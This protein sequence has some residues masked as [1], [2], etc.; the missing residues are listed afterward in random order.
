MIRSVPEIH[1]DNAKRG[2]P[3]FSIEFFPPKTEEG[4]SVL[5]SKTLPTLAAANQ[6]YCSVTYGAGGSTRDKTLG[7]VKRIQDDF[8]LTTVMHLTCVNAT[9]DEL[10]EVIQEARKRGVKNILALRGDPPGGTGDWVKT[11]GGFQ[12]S[13]EL[14][15]FLKTFPDMSI[16]TAGFPEGHIAQIAGREA[17]WEH[18]AHKIRQGAQFVVTQ[19]F[20]DTGRHHTP[21]WIHPPP[22]PPSSDG[23][24]IPWKHKARIENLHPT[25]ILEGSSPTPSPHV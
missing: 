20:F 13:S 25:P 6:D 3:S 15:A 22:F 17:D 11:E 4:E 19:L 18:L 9:R 21:S 1:R 12:Y 16:A 8:D 5:F 14:V 24:Y 10:S 23:I 7:M 2:R